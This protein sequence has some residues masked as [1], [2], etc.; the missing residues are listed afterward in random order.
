MINTP[1]IQETPAPFTLSEK[2]EPI[3]LI[4]KQPIITE[5]KTSTVEPLKTKQ[6]F[7]VQVPYSE[8][9]EDEFSYDNETAFLP[10]NTGKITEA[11]IKDIPRT[12]LAE[13]QQGKEWIGAVNA[14]METVVYG[15]GLNRTVDRDDSDFVQGVT[16]PQGVLTASAPSFKTNDGT[17]FTGERARLRIRQA[18]KLG[19]IFNIPL[20]HSGFWIRIKAPSEGDLLELYR[21]ITSE[22]I[23][24][25]RSSYGL[26][27]SNNTSYASKV[28]LDFCIENMYESSLAVA[29]GDD[30]RKYIKAPDLS[31]LFWGLACSVYSNG[32]Q[33]T[34]PCISDPEKCNYI[35]KEKLDLSKLLWTDSSSLTQYQVNHMTKRQRGSMNVDS[36]KKYTDDFIRGQKKKIDLS[37]SVSMIIKLPTI[38][39][40]I[41]SGYRWVNGIE[42]NYS[43]SLI[44]DEA[45]RDEYLLSQAKATAMRQY[46]HFV[47]SIEVAGDVY[48]DIDTIEEVLNDLTASDKLRTNFMKMVAEYLDNSVISLVAIPTFKCPNCGGEQTSSK[49][50]VHHPKLIPIDV[51]QTFFTLL[52][53]RLKKI[54]AR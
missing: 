12:R 53:S 19:V 14:G 17:K 43:K 52:I 4:E 46:A 48:D 42:E 24:L 51:I 3:P 9:L 23:S 35:I 22:K 54:E 2:E 45:K 5:E 39:E 32:F 44:K 13:T 16:S 41:D 28:L 38:V 27:F 47:E 18:L 25:G 26:L 11:I 31:V 6:N 33:Y 29:E 50:H 20:W 40:H 1:D 30:I 21:Q 49:E 7:I 34:R 37:D 15:D 8:K 36:V 10:A